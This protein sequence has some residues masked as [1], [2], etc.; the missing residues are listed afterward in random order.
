MIE[1]RL[2]GELEVQRDGKTVPLPPSKKTR[3][4]LAYLVGSGRPQLRDRLCGLL[5]DGPDDPRAELRWSL[6]KLRPLMDGCLVADRE[7]VEFLFALYDKLTSPLTA[8]LKE[9]KRQRRVKKT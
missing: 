7:R 1:I 5:W 6:T 3:A 4:L 2:L 8:G 9:P